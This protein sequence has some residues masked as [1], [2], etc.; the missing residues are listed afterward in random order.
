MAWKKI[1]QIPLLTHRGYQPCTK[2]L[3]QNMIAIEHSLCEGLWAPDV[4]GW[5]DS[6]PPSRLTGLCGWDW[7]SGRCSWA[8]L[9]W[10]DSVVGPDGTVVGSNTCTVEQWEVAMSPELDFKHRN[11]ITKIRLTWDRLI[12]IMGI[13]I[14]LRQY[15]HTEMVPGQR[16]L[17]LSSWCPL[18]H[19]PLRDLNT[20]SN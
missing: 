20:V 8:R 13:S 1:A 6:C 12:F 3:I 10:E 5:G 19:W 2:P 9:G 7:G 17:G 14:L 18:T 4:P 15:L 16:L 11:P